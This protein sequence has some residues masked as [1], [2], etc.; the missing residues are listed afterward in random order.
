MFASIHSEQQV[1][2]HIKL[3]LSVSA[4]SVKQNVGVCGR[5]RSIISAGVSPV[6]AK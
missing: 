3:Y 2:N 6:P 4:L 1:L 5:A